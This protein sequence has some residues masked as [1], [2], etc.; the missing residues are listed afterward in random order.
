MSETVPAT[1]VRSGG[2]L[3]KKIRFTVT[4]APDDPHICPCSHCQKRAGG[5]LQ[6]WVG[7]PL[8]GLSWT[9]DGE[10]TWYD[11]H[12]EKTRRGFCPVC[13]SHIAAQDYG[14]DNVIGI[15]TTALDDHED[16]PS[17]VPVNL[18]RLAD[19]PPWLAQAPDTQHATVG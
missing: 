3:C 11:T 18:N 2:C 7:F 5:P 17:L 15:N 13:G 9:G 16:D 12:P 4:G 14:D 1:E 19:A 8:A 6:W 10:L